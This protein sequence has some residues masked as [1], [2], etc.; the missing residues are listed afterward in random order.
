[1]AIRRASCSD[2]V[3]TDR[4][5]RRIAP[6]RLKGRRLLIDGFN[7]VTTVES[8]LG[9][10]ILFL[11]RDQTYR[12]IA[13][14]HGT[15]RRVIETLPALTLIGRILSSLE[16]TGAHWLFDRPVSNSGRIRGLVLEL[17][18][19]RGWE[20]TVDLVDSPDAV[21]KGSDEVVATADSAIL[22]RCGAWLNLARLV[23]D[24]ECPGATI[25]DLAV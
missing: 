9:G 5:V 20:W 6:D 3:L 21:L 16:V 11:C 14:V 23:V 19:D 7:V 25:V 12:D 13:G 18:R 22:D 17:A 8:A 4:L 24:G 10:G 2:A 1:M 15:Y